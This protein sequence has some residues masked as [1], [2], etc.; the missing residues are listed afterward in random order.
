MFNNFFKKRRQKGNIG[1]YLSDD[2]VNE[3]VRSE[4][5]PDLSARI[6]PDITVMITNMIGYV[7]IAEAIETDRLP[8][9]MNKYFE[10]IVDAVTHHGAFV[11]KFIGDKVI[12]AWNCITKDADAPHKSCEAALI[13]IE[14]IDEFN[15]WAS[16][17]DFPLA[18]ICIGIATGEGFAA[19][20]GS[21]RRF[22]Y[23]V[24]GK[25]INICSKLE[26]A[27]KDVKA[28]ILVDEQTKKQAKVFQFSES[29]KIYLNNKDYQSFELS[30][31]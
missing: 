31:N 16:K 29:T 20:V 3:M 17:M 6:T 19:N 2:L 15:E 11:D 28:R 25:V 12:S 18:D 13:Q 1:A 21:E 10:F 8:I 27:A 22:N 23:T 4:I 26:S 9:Y 5:K 7:G 14:K 24:T 30:R